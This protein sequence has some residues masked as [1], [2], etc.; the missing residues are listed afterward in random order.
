MK[1]A[2]NVEK[3]RLMNAIYQC[4]FAISDITLFLDTHPK[5]PDALDYFQHMKH[6]YNHFVAEYETKF[7]PLPR[8]ENRGRIIGSGP[9]HHGHGK[10]GT[11]N[12][13]GTMKKDY[14]IRFVSQNP[15]RRLQK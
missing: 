11:T 13:C 2:C 7:G 12:L 15:I 4:G 3:Q 8:P 9:Y 10:G 1:T 6:K 14:S 5:D